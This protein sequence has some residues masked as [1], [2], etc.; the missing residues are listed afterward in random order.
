MSNKT[1]QMS[2]MWK[3]FIEATVEIIQED[4]IEQVTIRKV[5]DRAGYNS[6]TIYN[7]FG[8]VSHLI[9]FASMKLLQDYVEEVSNYIKNG[10]TP[11]E[12]YWLSWECFCK[13]SFKQPSIFHAVFIMNLG[14][15]PE[16][17]IED[18]YEMY[19]AELI[20][21]PD[22]LKPI[23]FERRITMR[24]KSL[25]QQAAQQKQIA[26][27]HIESLNDMTILVW[28]GMLTNILNNRL[29]YDLATAEKK[30]LDYIH[31]LVEMAKVH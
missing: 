25:L 28:Q 9:F 24:G 14:D 21:V 12:K 13:H 15:H 1:I 10:Q 6:A 30:T 22:E 16:K 4:G 2:R 29:D 7:Y 19:P 23:L 17:L 11:L 3:Y 26:E 27:D 20:N 31:Q 8:E 18:Y 5:A